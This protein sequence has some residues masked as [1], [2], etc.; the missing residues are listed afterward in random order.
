MTQ[1]LVPHRKPWWERFTKRGLLRCLSTEWKASVQKP[2]PSPEAHPIL[3][4][5]RHTRRCDL[6]RCVATAK[7]NLMQARVEQ[8]LPG[9]W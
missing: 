3:Q 7:A 5:I 1:I 2:V 4:R 6:N 9:S 8:A